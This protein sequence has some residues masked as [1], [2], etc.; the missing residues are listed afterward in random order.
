MYSQQNSSLEAV[1]EL[2]QAFTAPA[3]PSSKLAARLHNFA[4]SAGI[5]SRTERPR[6]PEGSGEERPLEWHEVIE[7][8]AFSE[9]KVWIEEK[10][11]VSRVSAECTVFLMIMVLH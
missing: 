3:T 2:A 8:Q 6:S 7:L 11:R 4:L 9:R 10:T 5:P 1:S